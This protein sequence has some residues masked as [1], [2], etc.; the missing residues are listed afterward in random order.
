MNNNLYSNLPSNKHLPTG[1]EK[2]RKVKRIA[3]FGR[4]YF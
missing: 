3:Q 1:K 4:L 2:E